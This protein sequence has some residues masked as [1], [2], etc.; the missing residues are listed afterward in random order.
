V[1]SC[2]RSR[3][4]L[5][6]NRPETTAGQYVFCDDDTPV[7]PGAHNLWSRDWISDEL[8][9]FELGEVPDAKRSYSLG[10]S[11]GIAPAPRLI[12]SADCI[13]HGETWPLAV[14]PVLVGGF[15]A[16]CPELTGTPRVELDPTDPSNWCFWADVVDQTYVN[17]TAQLARVAAAYGAPVAGYAQNDNDGLVPKHFAF[18]PAPPLPVVLVLAGTDNALQWIAQVH[19]GALPP[20]QLGGF[21]TN[22]IWHIV[23]SLILNKML[24]F[25]IPVTQ[26]FLIVGHSMGGAVGSVTAVRLRQGQP[27][28]TIELLTLGSPRP[29]DAALVAILRTVRVASLA[30]EGDPVVSIPTNLGEM[31]APLRAIVFLRYPPGSA[32]WVYPPN[33][34]RVSWNGTVTPGAAQPGPTQALLDILLWSLT[35]GNFPDLS[36]HLPDEYKR[37]LCTPAPAPIAWFDA[38]DVRRTGGDLVG[39]WPN[40]VNPTNS[41]EAAPPFGS[42]TYEAPAQGMLAG[43]KFAGLPSQNDLLLIPTQLVGSPTS[44]IY[45]V[46]QM[47]YPSPNFNVAYRHAVPIEGVGSAGSIVTQWQGPGSALPGWTLGSGIH[48]I[49]L[50]WDGGIYGPVLLSVVWDGTHLV[51]KIENSS[52]ETGSTA[53]PFFHPGWNFV[54]GEVPGTTFINCNPQRLGEILFYGRV[55]SSA[56]DASVRAYLRAKWMM[57]GVGLVTLGGDLLATEA[58]QVLVT[59][60]ETYGIHVEE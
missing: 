58:G 24:P 55:L 23:S 7:Y 18:I 50:P 10:A 30:N 9:G 48:R 57:N 36:A 41:A 47:V 28:R 37:R 59:E 38:W 1:R 34:F 14:V 60:G 19:F 46:F 35:L 16:R 32:L 20:L 31:P 42:P 56:D 8:D 40:K 3:W 27:G 4:R 33:R 2:F 5:F 6:R 54:G 53:L 39:V 44:A 12:G 17:A 15:D 49:N 52:V 13:E 45:A 22:P 21:A 43:L 11:L 29:G 51:A 25:N 26:P